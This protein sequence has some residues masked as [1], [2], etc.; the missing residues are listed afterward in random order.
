MIFS[1]YF[2]SHG[3]H[4][5]LLPDIWS[6]LLSIFYSALCRPQFAL[7]N[8][9]FFSCVRGWSGETRMVVLRRRQE[10]TSIDRRWCIM[11]IFALRCQEC[12]L[13]IA[14][15]LVCYWKDFG[16]LRSFNGKGAYSPPF[17]LPSFVFLVTLGAPVHTVH[18]WEREKVSLTATLS[19]PTSHNLYTSRRFIQSM[20][21]VF[22]GVTTCACIFACWHI[23]GTLYITQTGNECARQSCLVRQWAGGAYVMWLPMFHSSLT[24]WCHQ[25]IAGHHF[26]KSILGT[27]LG[28]RNGK[29]NTRWNYFS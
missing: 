14:W 12:A 3:T 5:Y 13:S 17:V 24:T 22:T 26:E 29:Y 19:T 9:L 10:R 20:A 16:T 2:S 21:D 1:S 11:V 18:Q 27:L 8:L 4:P 6:I 23:C 15:E 7:Q 25:L 28:M